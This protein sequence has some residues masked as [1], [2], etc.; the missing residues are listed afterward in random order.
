MPVDDLI[1]QCNRKVNPSRA[2]V[3]DLA[4]RGSEEGLGVGA[5]GR[6]QRLS[7]LCQLFLGVCTSILGFL[8]FWAAVL[9]RLVG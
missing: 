6:R 8:F 3:K 5:T 1:R 7:W 2:L 4:C 9:F